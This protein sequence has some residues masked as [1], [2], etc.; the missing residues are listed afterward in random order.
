MSLKQ[1]KEA[2]HLRIEQ[3]DERFLKVMYAMAET[4]LKEQEAA[5]LERKIYDA[6]SLSDWKPMTEEELL[7]RLE[8][9]SAQYKK[10]QFKSIDDVEKEAEQW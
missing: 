8:E 1:L 7:S 4:Y 10:G 2:L 9:A 6:S 5:E 3:I